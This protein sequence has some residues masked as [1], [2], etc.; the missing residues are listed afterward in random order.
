M[1]LLLTG[2]L[3]LLSNPV[4]SADRPDQTLRDLADAI[5]RR[6]EEYE[7]REE[8]L[9]DRDTV[10][11]YLDGGAEIYLTY[12]FQGVLGRRYV[13]GDGPE[14]LFDLFDMGTPADAFGIFSQERESAA[15]ELGQ[16]SEYT[17][18][19]LRFWKHRFFGS[20]TAT[21]ITDDATAAVWALGKLAADA[22]V[23]E[24]SK[25]AILDLLPPAGLVRDRVRYLHSFM[26]LRH[27][28]NLGWQDI[29]HFDGRVDALL[30]EYQTSAGKSVVLAVEYRDRAAAEAG[31]Q[32]F[33]KQ[34]APSAEPEPFS[35]KQGNVWSAVERAG[36]F[37][38]IALEAPTRE[39]AA[40]LADAVMA[41]WKE[42]HD[43]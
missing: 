26:A 18:G 14:I 35:R 37:L 19:M 12:D 23:G 38:V 28:Y 7:C 15:G 3:F 1:S 40:R 16:G 39:E 25:P 9:Y 29:L 27:H 42:S 33:L 34:Y 31:E 30:A 22:V 36:S 10:F 32:G 6:V 20:V 41:R 5:P 8:G 21:A 11:D 2:W 4:N 24:G 17:A 43:D 13:R